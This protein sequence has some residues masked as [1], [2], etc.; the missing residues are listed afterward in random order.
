MPPTKRFHLTLSEEEDSEQPVEAEDDE[1]DEKK[2][3]RVQVDDERIE[4]LEDDHFGIS[5]F[6]VSHICITWIN[7]L[8]VKLK[9]LPLWP[10]REMVQA[11]MPQA[12]NSSTGIA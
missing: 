5:V 3:M 7:F 1:D 12:L 2:D 11:H 9:E 8:Y 6:T 10:C 4:H